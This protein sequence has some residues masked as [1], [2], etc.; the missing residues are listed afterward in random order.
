MSVWSGYV[1]SLVHGWPL[2]GA[3][4]TI[5]ALDATSVILSKMAIFALHL[6]VDRIML[7]L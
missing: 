4:V 5:S 7:W 2:A 1:G 6:H 3:D